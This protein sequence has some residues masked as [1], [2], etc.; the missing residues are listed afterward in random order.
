MPGVSDASRPFDLDSCYKGIDFR[1]VPRDGSFDGS[2][3][4]EAV[5][6]FAP[7][8]LFI[9]GWS[10]P[11]NRFL[12]TDRAF[13]AIPKVL[14]LDMPWAL[15][16]RKL[17]ARFVLWGYLR[18][19]DAALVPGA[20]SARYA[21]WLGFGG[22]RPI[23]Q[24]LLATDLSRFGGPHVPPRGNAFLYV[25]RYAP[26]KGLDILLESYAR[27]VDSVSDPWPLDCVGAGPL[28]ESLFPSAE[29]RM[30]KGIVRDLGFKQPDELGAVF[31]SHGAFV[32]PSR[33]ESWGVVLAEA[34]GAGLPIICT[35]ACGARHEVVRA[36]CA[37]ANGYVV[38]AGSPR[39]LADAMIRLHNL[40]EEARGRLSAQS[41]RL[42][43]PYSAE[44]WAERT[45][46]LGE[47]II[48]K[49]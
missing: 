41:R 5:A 15:R 47:E 26:E 9:T 3:I 11:A 28:R 4:R 32:L 12:A 10:I 42:A 30:G 13:R 33:R 17:A 39:S 48:A 2:A 29:R 7:D 34:A 43:A 8:L 37:D 16:P 25:G 27:Y 49:P 24:G 36:G 6:A 35:D 21:R 40:G 22:R 46:R 31:A 1:S 45:A 19:F 14:Q 18:H 20:T 44:A 38:R 23:Y